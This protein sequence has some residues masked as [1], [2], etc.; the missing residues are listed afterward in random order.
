MVAAACDPTALTVVHNKLGAIHASR[1]LADVLPLHAPNWRRILFGVRRQDTIAALMHETVLVP[2]GRIDFDLI[3]LMVNA[4]ES[5]HLPTALPVVQREFGSHVGVVPTQDAHV[6]GVF[7]E[8]RSIHQHVIC[9]V[10]GDA[11]GNAYVNDLLSLARPPTLILQWPTD[12][13]IE[14]AIGWIVEANDAVLSPIAESLNHI[15]QT[16]SEFVELLKTPTNESGL[17]G[18]IV[19][20][21]LIISSLA[22]DARCIARLRLLLQRLAIAAVMQN[23]Q[24]WIALEI[25]TATTTVLRFES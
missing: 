5:R 10:D 19:A 24:G 25:S 9:L 14:D 17:K 22:N 11:A 15:V 16:V 20:Y 23:P 6:V 18:D 13:G 3:N 7:S 8:L 21:E 4:D 2:E 1:L 12:W